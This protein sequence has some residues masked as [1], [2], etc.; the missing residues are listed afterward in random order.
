MYD[1]FH[2]HLI[3]VITIPMLIVVVPSDVV[4]VPFVFVAVVVFDS[5]IAVVVS[6]YLRRKTMT[7]TTIRLVSDSVLCYYS[8]CSLSSTT[9]NLMWMQMWMTLVLKMIRIS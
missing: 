4:V 6:D 3:I 7:M 8:S 5:A 9:M 1:V 2:M